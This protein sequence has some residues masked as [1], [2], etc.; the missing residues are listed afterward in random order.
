MLDLSKTASPREPVKLPSGNTYGVAN[1]EELGA[2][3]LQ[4]IISSIDRAQ[5]LYAEMGP[6]DLDKYEEALSVIL[7]AAV[8]MVPDAPREELGEV[9]LPNLLRLGEH[10]AGA[11]PEAED[12]EAKTSGS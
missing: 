3:P 7:D 9:S 1:P 10:F 8:V 4:R 12:G 11:S 6:D 5:A 2:I